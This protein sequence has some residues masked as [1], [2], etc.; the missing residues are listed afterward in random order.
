MYNTL[1]ISQESWIYAA[2]KSCLRHFF[3]CVWCFVVW[4]HDS[5]SLIA[6]LRWRQLIS[7]HADTEC[8]VPA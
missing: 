5:E 3:V 1:K 6:C 8:C 7:L 4:Q 2:H